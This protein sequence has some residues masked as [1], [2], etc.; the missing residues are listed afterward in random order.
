MHLEAALIQIPDSRTKTTMMTEA[1]R[2]RR[3]TRAACSRKKRRSK[4]RPGSRVDV[5]EAAQNVV[6]P[7]SH[8]GTP[9]ARVL[10]WERFCRW[11][12]EDSTILVIGVITS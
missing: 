9:L 6:V 11:R 3:A 12:N 5:D 7:L 8:T 2:A 1:R 10:W 4:I